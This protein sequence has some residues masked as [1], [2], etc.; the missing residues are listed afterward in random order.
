MPTTTLLQDK[1]HF[2]N[3]IKISRGN[4]YGGSYR[5]SYYLELLQPNSYIWAHSRCIVIRV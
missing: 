2:M 4:S 5:S 3:E 1:G